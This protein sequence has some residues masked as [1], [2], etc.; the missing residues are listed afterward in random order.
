VDT[1]KVEQLLRYTIAIAGQGDF[2]NRELGPIHLLKYVYLGDLAF[3]ER[4]GGQTYT[5][6]PWRFYK[7]G[8]W[9][10]PVFE[11][12]APVMQAVGAEERR[13]IGQYEDEAVR[14]YLDDAVLA[15]K[16]A[17]ELPLEVA[18]AV[19]R[20]VHRFGAD[21]TGLLY[22]VYTTP[23]MLHA[24][25][26][27]PLDFA[28]AEAPERPESKAAPRAARSTKER[29]QQRA[30]IL[31][32][33]ERVQAKLRERAAV[34]KMVPPEPPP[35]YDDVFLEGQAWLDALAGAPIEPSEGTV[36]FSDDIWKSRGR[37]DPGIP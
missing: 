36:T 7:F 35:R 1:N 23:P 27:E 22:H 31:E 26:N 2:S 33:R 5:G 19:R 21:T 9:A 16:L 29:K 13:G 37:R 17:D 32:L 6:A 3:A 15:D 14:W 30:T 10:A 24:A 25:P 8:P 28:V 34:R 12:I 18:S 11:R 20:A 4:N